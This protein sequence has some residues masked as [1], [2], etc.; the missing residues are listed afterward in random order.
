MMPV[1]YTIG[2]FN[3]YSFGIFLSLSF[4]L[5]TFIVW[6]LSK[7]EFKEEAYLDAYFY[8]S[9]VTIIFAR[10]VYIFRNFS[11][12]QFTILKYFLVVE[13][14]GLSLLGGAIGGVIFL[15]FYSKRNK[16][17]FFHITDILSVAGSL[18]LVFIKI[19]QQLGG[20]SFGSKT[21][22]FLKVRITGRP[23]FY[24][25]VELYETIIYLIL[26]IVLIILYR[27]S[28]RQKWRDGVIFSVF[29]ISLSLSAT[30]LEFLKVYRVYLYNLSFRQILGI[31]LLFIS[32]VFIA[33]RI[34][35]IKKILNF[36]KKQNN[37]IS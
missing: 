20:A 16:I 28:R 31:V 10:I 30:L 11:E 22:F 27:L 17:S 2:R 29:T 7:D 15:Y 32:S 3:V 37:E 24:H 23:G 35:I 9:L 25:P 19:G 18:A 34:G 14:P 1:L 33:E 13:T 6:K 26:F 5:S 4:I 12:F 21:D 36:F 8:S